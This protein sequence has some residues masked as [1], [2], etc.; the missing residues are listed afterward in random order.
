MNILVIPIC[1]DPLLGGVT[2]ALK[3]I[4]LKEIFERYSGVD[5]YLLCVDRD[6]KT[7]RRS[8]LDQLEQQAQA[9]LSNNKLFLAENAWQELGAARRYKRIRNLCVEDI[10]NLETRIQQRLVGTVP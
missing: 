10:Q 1:K 4:N 7:G 9:V 3:W 6:G 8:K 5:L 2:E